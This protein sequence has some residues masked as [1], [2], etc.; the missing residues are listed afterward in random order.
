MEDQ[1]MDGLK[2]RAFMGR[3]SW[4]SDHRPVNSLFSVQLAAGGNNAKPD[5]LHLL[6]LRPRAAGPQAAAGIGL[7]SSRF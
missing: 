6:L 7:R 5:H 2:Q 4:F 1:K 3:S